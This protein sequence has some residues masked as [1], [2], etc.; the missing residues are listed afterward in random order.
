MN[1][2]KRGNTMKW[3]KKDLT[4]YVQAKEFIDTIIIPFIPFHMIDNDFEKDSF[5]SETLNLFVSELEKELSGRILV[6]PNYHYIKT[7]DL[8]S[9]VERVNDWTNHIMKQ[10][11]KHL[12]FISFDPKWKKME[13]E[14]DG[15]LIWLPGFLSSDLHSEESKQQIRAQVKDVIELIR[16]FW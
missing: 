8:E 9:E 2:Q 5:Q 16:S 4:Q 7:G 3:R 6:T 12:F 13:R 1:F 11:F 15:T 14:L 10:P